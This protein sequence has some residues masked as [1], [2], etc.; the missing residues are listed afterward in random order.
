MSVDIDKF[1]ESVLGSDSPDPLRFAFVKKHSA[2]AGGASVPVPPPQQAGVLSSI[3]SDQNVRNNKRCLYIHVPFCRVRCTFCNFFQNAASRKL[4]D[5]YFATLMQDLKEKAA[6]PWTQSGIFHAVYIGGG[7]PTDLSPEQVRV[8]GQAI[9]DYFPL[10]S[11]CE[12]TLEG[13][14]NRFSDELYQGA[15]DGGFNRFSF[16]VQSFNT[17][18]R[19]SAKRLD[20]REDVLIRV[21]ELAKEDKIP[22]II[23]LLYGLPYQTK[24]ILEQDLNDFMSTGA[25]GLDLYQLVVGGTA[26]MLNLVEKGKIPPPATTP[27][28]AGMY[29]LGVNFMAKHHMKQLS[30]NHWAVDNRE[31]SLYNS[32]AKTYA[33]VLPIG[34]GA[35]GNIGGY[36]MMLHRTLDTYI[37]AV[38]EGQSTIAMMMKHSP[39]EPLFSALKSG[40]DRG[41]VQASKLP[42][43]MGSDTFDF[44]MPLFKV[45]QD[46]GLVELQERSLVLTLAGSFW[47]VSLAQA[48]IQVLTSEMNESVPKVSN[49]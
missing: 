28:K 43:F 34:C 31:R 17:Q 27:E 29:E 1:D 35:G 33:E 15:L 2:H 26:P 6:L 45:W 37:K 5:E 38:N 9:H 47:T 16:G 19:R 30:V 40:F 41:I 18:V 12:I 14:I 22:V 4:V 42:V 44:L 7:T 46:K 48:C 32:L 3:T 20:D 21:S 24:E 11:D 49:N 8:L 10:A 23:D 36:G 13:R 39:L 25:H